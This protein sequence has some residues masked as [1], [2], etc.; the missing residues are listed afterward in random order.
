MVY[1]YVSKPTSW[2][3]ASCG[4]PYQGCAESTGT[5]MPQGQKK[6]TPDVLSIA[7]SYTYRMNAFMK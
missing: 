6:L 1:S 4:N 2:V 5:M 7:Q 3:L